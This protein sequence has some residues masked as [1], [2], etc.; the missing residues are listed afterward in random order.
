MEVFPRRND[1]LFPAPAQI[2]FRCSCPD[3]AS[4][5]KHV[6]A[7]L[8]G[9]GARLDH[10][11]E[12]LFQLRHVDPQDLIHHASSFPATTPAVDAGKQLD[13]S[14]LSRLFGIELEDTPAKQ[15]GTSAPA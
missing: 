4:M 7:T 15:D 14:D 10:Q 5:C 11:P 13:P 8:Y 9:V 2:T 3:G 12:L 1:G 6:A